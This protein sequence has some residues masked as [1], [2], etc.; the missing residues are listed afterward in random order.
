MVAAVVLVSLGLLPS[1]APGLGGPL[2][3]WYVPSVTL[4][5]AAGG[6]PG[7]ARG[8]EHSLLFGPLVLSSILCPACKPGPSFEGMP[9][10][11]RDWIPDSLDP[12]GPTILLPRIVERGRD[13]EPGCTRQVL[14]P[15]QTRVAKPL[16]PPSSSLYV[17]CWVARRHGECVV[18][19][20]PLQAPGLHS[21]QTGVTFPWAR[22]CPAVH[23]GQVGSQ[24]PERSLSI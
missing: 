23:S 13:P 6:W 22:V 17:V 19:A 11:T 10:P 12:A 14:L 2:G 21:P 4:G 15:L 18:T 20:L 3:H 9:G 8:E 24:G 16:L 7:L 5:M 1:P